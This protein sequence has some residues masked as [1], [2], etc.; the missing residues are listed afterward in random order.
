MAQ[1]VLLIGT[2]DTKG[3]ELRYLKECL[4]SA[5]ADP[6]VVDVSVLGEPLFAA[7][8]P[9]EEI[10]ARAGES[11]GVSS[12]LNLTDP[13]KGL[14]KSSVKVETLYEMEEMIKG[15]NPPNAKDGFS[16]LQSPK[17]PADILPPIDQTL[18]AKGAELYKSHCQECHRPPVTTDAF[19]DFNNKDWWRTNQNGDHVMVLEN[20][21]IEHIGTDP[22]QA[23]RMVFLTGGAFTPQAREFLARLDRPHLE[24]PFSEQELRDAIA[25]VTR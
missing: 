19:Y 12:E 5:G 8:V 17:W 22:A 16:G 25:R 2:L 15:K 7:D 10:A 13:S 3:E 9:R 24:K 4:A 1:R 21:P 20:I 23:Q 14:F 18:A 6:E 11:L